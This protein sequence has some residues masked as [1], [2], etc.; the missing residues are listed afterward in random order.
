[1]KVKLGLR[2]W[3]LMILLV[4]SL[5]SIF[6]MPPVFLNEGVL[7]SEVDTNSTAFDLGFR[8]G[9]IIT[10]IDGQKINSF[11]DY[12]RIIQSKYLTQEKVKTT[13]QTS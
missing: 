4:L 7:I 6:G 3:I 2:L 8:K 12:N 10:E 11:E 9:Q 5:L 13:F 1:M